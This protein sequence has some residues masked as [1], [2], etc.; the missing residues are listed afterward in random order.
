MIVIGKVGE[1]ASGDDAGYQIKV[2][3][4]SSST[5]GFL[6]LTGKDLNNSNIEAFDSWVASRTELESYFVEANWVVAWE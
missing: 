4:D 1:I 5:G 3:D 6:I 2:V